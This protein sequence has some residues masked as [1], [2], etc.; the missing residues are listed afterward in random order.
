[1]ESC[2]RLRAVL[3]AALNANARGSHHG[4]QELFDELAAH[5]TAL[6]R[7]FQIGPRSPAEQRELE[8]GKTTIDGKT[9][10]VNVDF[11]RQ[12]IFLSQHLECSERVVSAL[13]HDV[14]V[15]N[16][17]ITPAECVEATLLEYH[18]RRRDL[19]DCL[20]YILEAAMV[21]ENDEAPT[22]FKRLDVFVRQGLLPKDKAPG[23]GSGALGTSQGATFFAKLMNEVENL[24]KTIAQVEAAKQNA[25][26]NTTIPSQAQQGVNATLGADILSIRLS[27]L[28]YERR[29]LATTLYLLSR[30]AYPSPAEVTTLVDWL[31]S[32]P[33]HPLTYHMLAAVLAVFDSSLSPPGSLSSDMRARLAIDQTVLAHM[34][35]KMDVMNK[36]TVPG[37]KAVV[38]LRW[39]LFLTEAR[40]RDGSLE[41]REGFRTEQ[42]ETQI[43]NAVQGDAF[44]YLALATLSLQSRSQRSSYPPPSLLHTIQTADPNHTPPAPPVEFKPEVLGAFESLVRGLI[45]HASSE[46]RKIK[47]RQEDLVLA[48][49]HG[50][51][52]RSRAFRPGQLGAAGPSQGGGSEDADGTGAPPRNDIAI[53]FSF[54]GVLYTALPTERAL[55]FWGSAPLPSP[56]G[57]SYPEIVEIQTPKLP[58]FLQW[59]VWSTQ[60]RDTAMCTAL[61]DMLS[62]L[63]HG[64]QCAELCYNF[65]ARGG[66]DGISNMG[67]ASSVSWVAIFGLLDNWAAQGAPKHERVSSTHGQ[68]SGTT[69]WHSHSPLPGSATA[70]PASHAPIQL[71]AK[72]VLFA[73]AFLRLLGTVVS[74]SVAVRTAIASHAQFRAI[75]ALVAL[76]PLPVP[77]ELKGALFETLSAF[78]EP[79]SSSVAGGAVLEIC[80]AVWLL[81]ERL[82]VINVRKDSGAGVLTAPVKGVEVELEE[83]EAVYKLYPA[84]LPFLKLLATLIHTPKRLPLKERLGTADSGLINSVPDQ[85]GAPYRLPGAGPFTAFV[86]D[87][88][89][90]KIG[91]REFQQP[92][93]RWRMNDLCLCYVERCLGSYELE[94][95]VSAA[96]N[97]T[98]LME[99]LIPFLTHPGYDVMKRLLTQ[100]PLQSTILGYVVEGVEGFD[101]GIAEI[102]PDFASTIVRVLRIVHRVLEIQDIFLDVIIP[103]LSEFDSAPIVG[104]AHPRSYFLKFDQALSFAPHYVPAIA[105]YV[106][107]PSYAELT[108]LAIKILK[109][110]SASH[111]FSKLATLIDHSPDS[112]RILAGF[113]RIIAVDSE[114][115]V[116]SAEMTME[117]ST[118][119]GAPDID[120]SL[121]IAPQATRLAALDLLIQN[122]RN[123]K[124]L[125]NLAHLLLFGGLDVEAI[126]D[127]HALG[128]QQS[129]IHVILDLLNEG[130]PRLK[131][132][133]KERTIVADPLFLTLPTLAE[134]C[135]RVVHQLCVHPRTSEMTMRYLRTQEDFFARHLVAIPFKAPPAED[136]PF[137]ELVYDDGSR[138]I[139][140]VAATSSFLRLRSLVLDLVALELHILTSK[141]HHKG[142]D[143]LLRLLFESNEGYYDDQQGDDL[144]R[145]FHDVGQSHVRIIELLQSLDF[146]WSDSLAVEPVTLDFFAG[147]N[148]QSCVR[149]EDNGCEVVD[150]AALLA[151]LAAARQTLH[152]Q[153]RLVTQ[154]HSDKA[155]QETEYILS[156]CAAENHRREVR[157]ATGMGYEAWKRLLDM[158]LTKCFDRLPSDQRETI[159]F[160]LL[161][162]LPDVLQSGNTDEGT[163]VLLSESILS[164]ITKL[165][166]D[167]RYQL[168]LQAA[169]GNLEAGALPA[170]RLF[171]LLRSTLRC[172]LDNNRLEVVRGNL[173]AALINF[174]HLIAPNDP[175][176]SDAEGSQK[177]TTNGD[178]FFD[179][180]AFAMGLDGPQRSTH[181][182][183]T[184]LESTS[185]SIIKESLDQ[186][187]TIVARDAIDGSEIWKTV[188]FM[189]LDSLVQLSHAEKTNVIIDTLVRHGILS[190]LVRS[191]SESDSRLQAVLAPE[192]DDVNALYVYEAK[193]SFFIRVSQSRS[194]AERLLDARIVQTLASCDYLDSRPEADQAFI[195][196]DSFLPSAVER[197]HQLFMPA[198]QLIVGI[199]SALGDGHATATKQVMNFLTSHRETIVILLKS[200]AEMTSVAVIEEV[201]VLV[202]LCASILPSVPKSELASTITGLGSVHFAILSLSARCL[203]NLH[204]IRSIQPQSESDIANASVAAP[205]EPS[206]SRFQ[207]SVLKKATALR[208]AI[209]SY[210]GT[211]SDFTEPEFSVVLSPLTIASRSDDRS[212]RVLAMAPTM[213]DAIEALGDL[214]TNLS[215]VLRQIAD[216]SAEIGSKD[217]IRIETIREVVSLPDVDFLE[218]LDLTEKQNLLVRELGRLKLDK[219]E[220][221]HNV[222]DVL[223]MLLLLLWRH[224]TQYWDMRNEH[225]A[226]AKSLSMSMSRLASSTAIPDP[227]TLRGEAAQKLAPVIQRLESLTV[228]GA[229]LG[230]D[231][232]DSKA[233]LDI[234]CK[235]LRDKVGLETDVPRM[236]ADAF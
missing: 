82:E 191:L 93:D 209:V 136:D 77:L 68:V 62:G 123:G 40:R 59:S 31:A 180:H 42:L 74:F 138:V 199:L 87:E 112:E 163:A 46:L 169:S 197:Y 96:D 85:L 160:D 176:A 92:S 19:V 232:R 216:L 170:E 174:M 119:A 146:D 186:L 6:R 130:V 30:M 117:D 164:V 235:R 18:K 63:A 148:L 26:S 151:L 150:R 233:Y 88:V 208:Q 69:G 52:E 172:I 178:A 78:C 210:L 129:C 56:S 223:E 58:S 116:A 161:H 126:Q 200:D 120:D 128:A 219:Q 110:L 39:T 90:A 71:N 175:S 228:D 190:N 225:A 155:A 185:L 122:T 166:E 234:M 201:T 38:L 202:E 118:G 89:F 214:S 179:D 97:G 57:L 231:W 8:S 198:L 10:A 224:L 24:G 113:R 142:V 1:M 44:A 105:A 127:P 103:L 139:S 12:A 108:Y 75:P 181:L 182:P 95:L 217:H 121:D 196:R 49:A 5:R 154:A 167:R 211:A 159:L 37:L 218:E 7:L 72:D 194:G 111:A 230:G 41:A 66:G 86:I 50:R 70:A 183:V 222:L 100:T 132:K 184:T 188:A 187:L 9:L 45:S 165:R 34:K 94:T 140:T 144:L 3:L 51:P 32:N 124:P 134:R 84:T 226:Q 207:V 25:V 17:N 104:I 171:M 55:Q 189:F 11:A 20:R 83:V 143:D 33:S 236:T 91:T 76:I 158:I 215:T 22:L 227:E 47:Q 61:H 28:A 137:I 168:L 60:P 195:D 16:P 212:Q 81:M 67:G 203:G 48:G 80:R 101:K 206:K 98:L 36:W 141:R 79:G 192:P 13:L 65:V 157:H 115:D 27:S 147:L 106:A 131:G 114:D 29:A 213:G 35:N 135:Y 220:E 162:V 102:E 156:S 149:A 43:W 177:S 152:A 53:L 99:T 125:P 15:H 153:G 73:Q 107:F 204:W 193:L 21:A 54:I 64:R 229:T 2:A 23:Q 14:A 173:Y 221:A 145:P 205:G 109:E 133:R 4:E